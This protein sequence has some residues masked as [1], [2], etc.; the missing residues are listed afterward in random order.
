[1]SANVG[2]VVREAASMVPDLSLRLRRTEN[3]YVS[4][5]RIQMI[6]IVLLEITLPLVVA[7]VALSKVSALV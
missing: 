3:Y 6:R 1:M 5:T 7:L 2:N 4:T